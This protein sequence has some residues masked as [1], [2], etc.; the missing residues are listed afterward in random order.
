MQHLIFTNAFFEEELVLP[1]TSLFSLIFKHPVYLQLHYLSCLIANE[2]ETPLLVCPPEEGYFS[3][4]E[5]LGIL[6]RNCAF[7]QD[8]PKN[9]SILHSWGAS[10]SLAT[11]AKE[12]GYSYEIPN[13]SLVKQ[14]N[15]KEFSFQIGQKLPQSCLI[16]TQ[17]E[18]SHW[19][20]TVQGPKVLKTLHGSSGRGH[21]VMPDSDLAK[22][23]EFFK[24]HQKNSP[25]FLAEPW[26]E[27]V[28]DFSTQWEIHKDGTYQYIG[29]TICK[30]SSKGTYKQSIVGPEENLFKGYFDFLTNH[31]ASAKKAIEY[32]ATLGFFGNLGFDAM[33]YMKNN[34]KTLHPIVE[35]NARKTMGWVALSL[36][37]KLQYQDITSFG[38]EMKK[39]NEPNLLPNFC[40]PHSGSPT[41]FQ[42]QFVVKHE[43]I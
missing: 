38:Y 5:K 23:L 10:Q 39:T 13:L 31:I 37:K 6:N 40:H 43:K 41:F 2:S 42:G 25:C 11:F 1:A 22:A 33:I 3:R 16:Y 19:L 34:T 24:K 35:I 4:I 14:I 7:L 26:V 8:S 30:N 27:R 15:S 12:R 21:F 17:E 32:I 20:Q 36:Y 18:L 28:L 9:P 29:A